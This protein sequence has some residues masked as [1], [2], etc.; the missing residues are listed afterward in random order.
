MRF[1]AGNGRP[2]SG[3][4]RL[5]ATCT[6]LLRLLLD[7]VQRI[8]APSVGVAVDVA[9]S[10]VPAGIESF[11]TTETWGARPET[12]APPQL[13]TLIFTGIVLPSLK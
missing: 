2:L 1:D 12:A 3:P 4:G 5:R 13:T 6:Q 8:A 9:S 10:S 11:L 7:A